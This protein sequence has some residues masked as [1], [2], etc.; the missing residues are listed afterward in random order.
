MTYPHRLISVC[1][2][3]V[4]RD[5]DVSARGFGIWA[6]LVRGIHQFLGDCTVNS[7]QADI[8]ASPEDVTPLVRPQVH[9]GVDGTVGWERD[10]SF[11]GSQPYRTE[12]AG[13]PAGGK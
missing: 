1:L 10:L 2:D 12:E 3:H 6:N 5:F 11:A 8:Q 9:F 13:R 4:D 7:R